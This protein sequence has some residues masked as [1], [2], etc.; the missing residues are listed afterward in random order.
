[1]GG[2]GVLHS[3]A[4]LTLLGR[5]LKEQCGIQKGGGESWPPTTNPGSRKA[6]VRFLR[7]C[8]GSYYTEPHKIAN[9]HTFL[10]GKKVISYGS[11]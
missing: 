3:P 7:L 6:L 11:T 9:I 2:A 5:S 10:D 1:M 4:L 8:K